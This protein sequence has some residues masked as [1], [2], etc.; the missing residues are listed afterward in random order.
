MGF[1]FVIFPLSWRIGFWPRPKKSIIAFGPLRFVL[2]K[3]PGEWVA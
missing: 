1:G 3:Q 2:H